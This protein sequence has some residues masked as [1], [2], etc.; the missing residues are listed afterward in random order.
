M[1]IPRQSKR[2]WAA[3]P[4]VVAVA[5]VL[6]SVAYVGNATAGT[7]PLEAPAN[8]LA[9]L[10]VPD[11][12]DPRIRVSRDASD[13]PVSGYTITRADGATLQVAGGA[14]TY[15]DHTVE[16]GTAYQH[17]VAA[18]N[19]RG[20]GQSSAS[21]HDAPS[22]PG[23]LAAEVAD[24]DAADEGGSVTLTWL[25]SR[26]ALSDGNLGY[27]ASGGSLSNSGVGVSPRSNYVGIRP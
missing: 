25:A 17:A 16:P 20:S 26:V 3:F 7:G 23:E 13:A 10:I 4:A 1:R 2:P 6:M 19:A 12:G 15:S 5:A 18:H 27:S 11:H 24:I 14:T 21:V 9:H 8:P 22:Q